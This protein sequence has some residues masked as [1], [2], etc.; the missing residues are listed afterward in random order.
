M[1]GPPRETKFLEST[2][3]QKDLTRFNVP[4][5]SWRV[6]RRSQTDCAGVLERGLKQVRSGN[7][8]PSHPKAD[9]NNIEGHISPIS[10]DYL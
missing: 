10:E 2:K 5:E 7:L 8:T 6:V 9:F 3:D 4:R 1:H